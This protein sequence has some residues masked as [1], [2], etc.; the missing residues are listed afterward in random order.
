[1][2]ANL[3]PVRCTRFRIATLLAYPMQE[4]VHEMC[5]LPLP[6]AYFPDSGSDVR[7]RQPTCSHKR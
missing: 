2:E 3:V 6:W 1:M 4:K 7:H 5:A